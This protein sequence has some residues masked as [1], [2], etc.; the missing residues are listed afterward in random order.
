[1]AVFG[2]LAV[3]F[4]VFAGSGPAFAADDRDSL[5]KAKEKNQKKIDQLR[6]ELEDVDSQ[7][8][9]AFVALETA[10]GD[11]EIARDELRRSEARYAEAQREFERLS[12]S[13]DSA[14]SERDV[15]R[16]D[17]ARAQENAELSRKSLGRL[18]RGAMTGTSAE[19]SD[20]MVLLGARDIEDVTDSYVATATAARSRK[21]TLS[22]AQQE[23]GMNRN[24]QA[25]LE[26]VTLEIADLTAKAETALVQ[27]K[28]AKTEAA[29]AKAQVDTL[30]A[31]LET[32]Q[33]NLETQKASNQENLEQ[34]E[35][36]QREWQAQID[37]IVE[38]E[39]AANGGGGSGPGPAPS[40][41]YFGKP[42]SS[43][44]VTSPFG[45]RV[46]PITGTRRFHAGADMGSGCGTPIYASAAGTVS[47][48]GWSGGYGNRTL[49][50][51]GV[52]DGSVMMSSYNHQSQIL[53]GAGQHVEKGQQIGLV[54][55]T[56]ASTGCHLHFEIY[57]NGSVV[58][59]MPYLR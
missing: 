15:V 26:Q 23:A 56:G 7:L 55:T 51:H 13:L 32:L 27:A 54:G 53:V 24:R 12:D 19:S 5:E 18:A 10:K 52:V 49:I 58:D 3:A 11:L 46:H 42:L 4:T 50:T 37:K 40:S 33:D 41:G 29:N 36:Q 6:S 16:A 9:D 20:L 39:L 30:V 2:A 31:S 59:P 21:A 48:A 35:A 14:T 57:K 28:T 22:R 45:W 43:V 25:R 38:Q 34:A 47:V 8:A 1:V 44:R 17:L